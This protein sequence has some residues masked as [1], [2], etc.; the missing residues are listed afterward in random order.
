LK[1][2]FYLTA[3]DIAIL[4]PRP[5]QGAVAIKTKGVAGRHIRRANLFS[6]DPVKKRGFANS[7]DLTA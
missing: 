4:N 5:R 6:I 1:K 3:K 7:R 2:V